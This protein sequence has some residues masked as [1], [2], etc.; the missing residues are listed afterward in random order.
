MFQLFLDSFRFNLI[1]KSFKGV[2]NRLNFR[3]VYGFFH[4]HFLRIFS[5]CPR[6]GFSNV[7]DVAAIFLILQAYV[8]NLPS[9][10]QWRPPR[11]H[12][13]FLEGLPLSLL[14]HG[15]FKFYHKS[16]GFLGGASSGSV[17]RL[18]RSV[19]LLRFLQPSGVVRG[20]A[21]PQ[22]DRLVKTKPLRALAKRVAQVCG[23]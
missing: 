11:G 6:T 1:S 16:A 23:R 12:K 18:A 21:Y 13:A 5:T 4:G 14:Q 3:N 10:V 15:G 17:P 2:F 9:P 22:N 20:S 7:R 19:T 8:N